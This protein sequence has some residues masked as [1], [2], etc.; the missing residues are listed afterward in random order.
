MRAWGAA[1]P[2]IERLADDPS[3]ATTAR[4]L[5]GVDGRQAR[6]LVPQAIAGRLECALAPQTLTAADLLRAASALAHTQ[7]E[8]RALHAH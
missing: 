2:G 1:Y 7:E 4:A 3:L 5:Q 6:K 8:V